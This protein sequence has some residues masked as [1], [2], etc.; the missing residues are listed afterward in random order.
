M[1]EQKS[2]QLTVDEAYTQAIDHFNAERYKEADKLCTAIIQAFPNHLDALN[3]LGV[4]AQKVNRHELAVEQFQRAV[5]INNNSALLYY[6]MGISLYRLG[7]REEAVQILQTALEKDPGNSQISDYLNGVLDNTLQNTGV[8][9]VQIDAQEA[10]QRGISFHQTGQLDE[11]IQ[12][13]RKVLDIQPK[14]ISAFCNIGV[15]LQS[16]GKLSEAIVSYKKAISIKPDYASAYSNL[17]YAL[18]EHGKLDEA[19]TS[20]QKAISIK[21]DYA[22]AYYNLG[23]SLKEQGKLEEAV[24]SYQKAIS[25]KPDY[26]EAYSNLGYTLQEQGKLEEAVTSYQKAI[27]IKPDYAEAYYNLGNTLQEQGKLEEAVS[28][29]QKAISIKPDYA[30]AYSHLGNALQEQGKLEE[31]I[32]IL[33]T[34]LNNDTENT[35]IT[36]SLIDLLN[37]HMPTMGTRGT[38]VKA[39]NILQRVIHGNMGMSS[40]TDG[41]VSQLYQHCH[42]ILNSH[43]LDTISY[44]YQMY[45]GEIFPQN[46][47][48]HLKIFN[49]F[50]II[51][52]RCFDC[53]K[54]VIKP[55]TV[56]ELFKLMVVFCN[57]KLPYDNTRKCM[58]EV[59]PDISGTYTGLIYCQSHDQGNKILKI[60][61]K[62]VS[63][64]ISKNIQLSIK[65]GCSE[66]PI[67]YP[68]YG[69][70]EK[71][72]IPLMSYNEKWR[73]Y[74][75]FTENN[76]ATTRR[77]SSL[78]SNNHP[79]FTVRDVMVMRTWLAY[80]AMIGDLSY[81]KLSG[82][83]IQPL[84][85]E[86]RPQF[87]SG[88][89]Q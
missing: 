9:S 32:Q 57:I 70:H 46:C 79:G 48:K 18:Q 75:D 4:T 61:K 28:S 42:N 56:V 83:A 80:A 10:L 41:D 26:A 54:V 82:S 77:S 47:E 19:V 66:Y 20:F 60:V 30:E 62:I 81:L 64:R 25:I 86:T 8:V 15:A 43:G 52:K 24:S 22:E 45:R 14:N 58:V 17:G 72:G 73:K 21:P 65:R 29:Y 38:H 3:L 6:N 40:I 23:N 84:Q 33:Q 44:T 51:P 31:A 35:K 53:Y 63:D 71:S 74:E 59:R 2:P 12:W 36:S 78:Y 7:R 11:A 69:H 5:N 49:T 68:E 16:Q 27:S 13:Y 85:I 88:E 76:L 1:T 55:R 39:Q 89:E 34:A 50:N 87:K 37:F 67:A